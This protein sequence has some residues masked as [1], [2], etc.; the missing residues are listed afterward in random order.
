MKKLA[1]CFLIYDRINHEEL[2]HLFF[3]DVDPQKYSIHIHY[4]ENVPLK[5]FEQ[6]KLSNCI[7]TIYGHISI[8]NAQNLLFEDALKDSTTSHCILISNSC[9]PFKSFDKVYEFIQIE[10]SYINKGIKQHCF[11]RCNNVLYY[12]GPYY[13]DKSA[14]WCILNRKHAAIMVNDKDYI[15][16]FTHIHAPDEHAYI[17]KLHVLNLSHEV[18]FTENQSNK[19]TTF[20]N[21]EGMDYKYVSQDNLKNYTSIM[22]EELEYLLVSP[23]LFGRKFL[24]E[25]NL[26]Y[27][28][29]INAIQSK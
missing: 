9:I 20:I 24:P 10:Y 25:C 22:D 26:S 14:Q 7:P 6:Y 15:Q 12:I 3:K 1:F 11:P 28:P 5:Y 13:I 4:K 8:I 27:K 23:C 19:A 16:W 17:T 21:W 18:I 2:W 29:Y